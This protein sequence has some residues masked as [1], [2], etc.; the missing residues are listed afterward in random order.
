MWIPTEHKEL[1]QFANKD[2]IK[3][4]ID[5]E[6]LPEYLGGQCTKNFACAPPECLSVSAMGADLG[7]TNEEIDDYLKIYEP[8]IKETKKCFQI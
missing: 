4:Y 5:S 8:V 6:Q 7:I 2:Q 3:D 1:V